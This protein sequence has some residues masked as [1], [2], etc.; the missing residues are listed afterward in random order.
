MECTFCDAHRDTKGSRLPRKWKRLDSQPCCPECWHKQFMLRAICLPVAG[1]VEATWPEFR[2]VLDDAWAQTTALSNWLM[3]EMYARDVHRTPDMEKLPPMPNVYLYPEARA[4]FPALPPAAIGSVI[5]CTRARYRASRFKLLWTSETSLANY[6]FPT[7]Y[8][9]PAAAWRP[10]LAKDGV[11]HVSVRLGE[12]RWT[13]RLRSGAHFRHQLR[14]FRALVDGSAIATELALY[15]TKANRSDHRSGHSCRAPGGGDREF[16]RTMCKMTVWLRREE[17]PVV[18]EGVLYVGTADDCFWQATTLDGSKTWKLNAD[19]VR[20]WEL[21]HRQRNTRLREDRQALP[22]L[23]RSRR[24]G[25]AST[26]KHKRRVTTF[27]HV[28]AAE[29]ARFADKHRISE[30]IY[31]DSVSTYLQDF[32]WHMARG[33]LQDK[34]DALGIKF[35]MDEPGASGYKSRAA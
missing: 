20:R 9:V 27:C 24:S 33:F 16:Y 3:T 30:V 18:R 23:G 8:P 7:P 34:L 13:L 12:T 4:N 2:A 6:R 14:A 19:H 35:S 5:H 32:P 31:D 29:L 25:Q 17:S 21:Q 26:N 10:F 1:P 11:P 22:P 15:R 28:A